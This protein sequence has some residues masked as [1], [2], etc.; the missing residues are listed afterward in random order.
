MNP[1]IDFPEQKIVATI[2]LRK[3]L[4]LYVIY[5]VVIVLIVLAELF[6]PDS[7][8]Q[9]REQSDIF[10]GVV[11]FVF[12]GTLLV[13]PLGLYYSIKTFRQ[14]EGNNV[15]RIAHLTGHSI[16]VLLLVIVAAIFIIDIS[17]AF[18]T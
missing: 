12:L 5:A 4:R 18:N 1:I 6:K 7:W 9:S 10:Y 13:S 3:S 15:Q 8:T 11:G 14:R 17:S 16:L 2:N